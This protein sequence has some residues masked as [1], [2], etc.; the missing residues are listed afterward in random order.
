MNSFVV[1]IDIGEERSDACYLS[2]A[3][4]TLDQSNFQMTDT[5]W[6]ELTSKFP[7]ETKVAYE[8]SGLA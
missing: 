2:S 8:A 3:C 5:G 6:S 1:G 4:D 7:K